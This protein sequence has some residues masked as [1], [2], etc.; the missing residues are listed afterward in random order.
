MTEKRARSEGR[1]A[2]DQLTAALL[3]AVDEGAFSVEVAAR[4]AF[5]HVTRPERTGGMLPA[6]KNAILRA[7]LSSLAQHMVMNPDAHT[8]RAFATEAIH[9]AQAMRPRPRHPGAALSAA[10]LPKDDATLLRAAL[11]AESAGARDDDDLVR[12]AVTRALRERRRS[13]RGFAR[14]PL[15]DD[16]PLRTVLGL[17]AEGAL[18]LLRTDVRQHVAQ[19]TGAVGDVLR[20]AALFLPATL[21]RALGEELWGLCR[22][23]GFADVRRTRV[24]IGVS[25]SSVAQEVAMRKPDLLARLRLVPGF[26]R[27]RDVRFEVTGP[28]TPS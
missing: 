17:P 22:I 13:R 6:E 8:L 5:L 3:T 7:Q 15:D 20:D 26:E 14:V 4:V 25:S 1:A 23:L 16:D 9:V 12:R 18:R 21:R 11:Y 19:S 2:I 24:L 28:L 27:V 10:S